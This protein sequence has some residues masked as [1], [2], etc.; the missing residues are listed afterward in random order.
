M[1]RRR[2]PCLG[3]R[4][5]PDVCVRRVGWRM[6]G[7]LLTSYNSFRSNGVL[8]ERMAAQPEVTDPSLPS[9]WTSCISTQQ[10]TQRKQRLLSSKMSGHF[11]A[12]PLKMLG[13]YGEAT[14]TGE[15]TP[16]PRSAC[17]QAPSVKLTL[18]LG[19]SLLQ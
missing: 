11:W 4:G 10:T 19:G 6:A 13:N 3:R 17:L 7:C 18:N 8:A 15:A 1:E 16:R 9:S 12:R 14:R 5:H 2:V